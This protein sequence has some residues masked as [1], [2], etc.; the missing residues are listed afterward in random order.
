MT[1]SRLVALALGAAIALV[2]A[3]C[4]ERP[5]VI[6]YKQGSYQGKQDTLPYANATFNGNKQEWDNALRARAQHQ[7]EYKRIH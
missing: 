1:K 2:L 7:N 6:V 4:G 3:G 5:Q